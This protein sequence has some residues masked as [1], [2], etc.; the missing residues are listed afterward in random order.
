MCLSLC[1]CGVKKPE[2]AESADNKSEIQE[3]LTGPLETISTKVFSA[4]CPSGWTNM[5]V[6]DIWAEKNDELDEDSLCFVKG[7]ENLEE[8]FY[9]A[10]ARMVRYDT[11]AYVLDTST[12][13]QDVKNVKFTIGDVEWEGFTG[14]S[15][16]D[17]DIVNYGLTAKTK[18]AQWSV[19]GVLKGERSSF[20]FEDADF[21]NILASIKLL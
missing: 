14:K 1:S 21:K 11:D 18:D 13:F 10:S 4:D 5:P 15:D 20:N 16:P 2:D 9:Y 8:A 3:S 12:L 17:T 6:Y 7:V 19:T